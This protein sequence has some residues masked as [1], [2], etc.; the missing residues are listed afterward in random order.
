[1]INDHIAS[2]IMVDEGEH[3][4]VSTMDNVACACGSEDSSIGGS[5]SPS[6]SSHMKK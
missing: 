1:M 5:R 2:V 4:D 6:S 3:D